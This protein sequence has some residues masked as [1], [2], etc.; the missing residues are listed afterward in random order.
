MPDTQPLTIIAI[1]VAVSGQEQAL[2]SAQEKL[3]AETVLEPG[4]IR[5]EL[6]QSHDDGRVLIFVESWETEAH[7]QAH[8]QGAAIQRYRASGAKDFVAEVTLHRM[9]LVADGKPGPNE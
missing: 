6:H 1:V 5:Y 4:C 2:R 9:K 7:W 8:M 3:V